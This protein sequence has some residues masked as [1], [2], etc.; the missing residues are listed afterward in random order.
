MRRARARHTSSRAPLFAVRCLTNS[1]RQT[2]RSRYKEERRNKSLTIELEDKMD[3]PTLKERVGESHASHIANRAEENRFRALSDVFGD[4]VGL[5]V[6]GLAQRMET[7]ERIAIAKN[8]WDH[9]SLITLVLSNENDI[10]VQKVILEALLSL[11]EQADEDGNDN[12]VLAN[13]IKRFIV[14]HDFA[15]P[16]IMQCMD[17]SRFDE[18][19]T[20]QL[21]GVKLLL[22]LQLQCFTMVP[23][24][25]LSPSNSTGA[26]FRFPALNLQACAKIFLAERNS[27]FESVEF[28]YTSPMPTASN[29]LAVANL[30]IR[31]RTAMSAIQRVL[32]NMLIDNMQQDTAA[33]EESE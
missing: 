24:A 22:A 4:S 16:A 10:S 17:N 7:L 15:I 8:S 27:L 5:V 32:T 1:K 20:I 18:T 14:D 29:M 25:A 28:L 33:G 26:P 31:M 11:I 21:V 2:H 12:H 23:P 19:W 3:S 9:S 30:L 13:E 6:L